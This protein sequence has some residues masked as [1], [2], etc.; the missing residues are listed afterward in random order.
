MYWRKYN[1]SNFN[2]DHEIDAAEI[3]YE[4]LMEAWEGQTDERY[5]FKAE[6]LRNM[7]KFKESNELLKNPLPQYEPIL[8]KQKKWARVIKTLNGIKY[9]NSLEINI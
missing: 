7:G 6:M 2:S 1:Q 9:K 4:K 3:I 5:L 8:A